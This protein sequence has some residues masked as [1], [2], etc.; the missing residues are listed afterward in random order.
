M[1]SQ[2]ALIMP[3]I[4]LITIQKTAPAPPEAIA[5][6]TPTMLPVPMHAASAAESACVCDIEPLPDSRLFLLNILPSV[7]FI[8][9]LTCVIWKNPDRTLSRSPV[10]VK[11]TSSGTPQITEFIEET[12]EQNESVG[13]PPKNEKD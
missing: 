13:S 3:I 12:R 8:H 9:V 6:A 11:A 7:V 10:P 5:A 2:H 4:A 1:F